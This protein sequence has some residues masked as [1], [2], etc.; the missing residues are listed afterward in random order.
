MGEVYEADD[1]VLGERVAVKVMRAE[2]SDPRALAERFRREVLLARRV[3]HPGV[4]RV[5]DVAFHR[6][7]QGSEILLLTMELIRGETLGDRLRPGRLAPEVVLDLGRQIGSAI[8]AAHAE[9]VLHRDIKPANILLE[10]PPGAGLRAVVTDFGL[11]RALDTSAAAGQTRIGTLL[12]TPEYMAPELLRGAEPSIRSDLYSFGVVLYQMATGVRPYPADSFGAGISKRLVEAPRPIADVAPDLDPIWGDVLMR[13]LDPDPARRFGSC[14]ELLDM[15]SPA[16]TAS[17]PAGRRWLAIAAGGFGLVGAALAAFAVVAMN[18]HRPPLTD[19]DT[20]VLA[21]FV[22]TTG[23]SVF[24]GTL[25]QGLSV[26]LRQSPFLDILA[27]GRVRETL[28]LMGRAPDAALTPQLAREACIR[29]STKAMLTGSI[30]SL[31]TKYVVGLR[32]Q[33]CQS[34]K[35]LAHQQEQ[36][37]RKEDVL[38]AVDKVAAS[39]RR[40][41]GESLSTV[42]KYDTPLYQATTSSLEALQAYSLGWKSWR[43]QGDAASLVYQKRAVELDADFAMAHLAMGESY[44]NLFQDTQMRESFT[45]AYALRNRASERERFRIVSTYLTFVTGELDRANVVSEQWAAAYPRD[46]VPLNRMQLNYLSLGDFE[47][48]AA[49]GVQSRQLVPDG[50]GANVNLS[51]AYLALNRLPDA[52]AVVRDAAVRVPNFSRM[53]MIRYAIA[54]LEGDAAEMRRQV[55]WSKGKPGNEDLLL[56]VEADTYAYAGQFDRG[57]ELSREAAAVAVRNDQAEAAAMW[58]ISSALRDAEAG[59][60][61]R[62]RELTARLLEPG[63]SLDLRTMAALVLARTGAARRA[64]ALADQI[65]QARPRDANLQG[66]WLPAIRAAIALTDNRPASALEHLKMT[67]NQELGLA[68]PG[69]AMYPVY[70]RG[71][72]FLAL[73][74]AKEAAAE[75]QKILD[76][77]GIV[78]N[79]VVGALAHLQ[80]GRAR[81]M[82][83]DL[84]GARTAYDG[85]FALWKNADRDV[86]ILQAARAEYARL[87]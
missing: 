77:R 7:P 64:A 19:K 65:D 26:K 60:V 71:Q 5:H 23:D 10:G 31:G 62:A 36:V 56:S 29:T 61:T 4:C 42:E 51:L 1:A 48:A 47:R 34:G 53:H 30:S 44:G 66:Y 86:P 73:G 74:R 24:D 58:S 87:R 83:G 72:V 68:S 16:T 79:F 14:R 76:H 49:N 70:L 63:S 41:L 33:E 38:N 75:F 80:L 20:I 32:A 8:D 28:K 22:N 45:K 25:K 2:T 59:N 85:Y 3:S 69:P 27:E 82:D 13:A 12:G 84:E 21:D 39:V 40:T 43:E 9:R 15:L 67:S 81:A 55:E 78:L 6:S 17:A 54:F 18:R 37:S 57:R 52:K 46:V 50:L 35:D 11:A